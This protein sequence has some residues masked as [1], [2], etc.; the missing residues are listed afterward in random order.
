MI[1]RNERRSLESVTKGNR[2]ELQRNIKNLEI[3]SESRGTINNNQY[4]S[5]LAK[6]YNPSISAMMYTN[7]YCFVKN[8]RAYIISFSC[9]YIQ[10]EEF[11][12]TIKKILETIEL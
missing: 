6:V 1:L 11:S 4:T 10:R 2:A 9:E 3:I 7:I 8:K 5:T 12:Q